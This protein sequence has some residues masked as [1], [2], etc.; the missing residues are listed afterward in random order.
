PELPV[1]EDY[2]FSRKMK[3]LGYRP[4]MTRR[5]ILTSSRRYGKGTVSILKTEMLMWY[6]RM[7]YRHGADPEELIE[8]YGDI[9]EKY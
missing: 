8:M 1:M 6:L 2:G 3:S 4:V 9:R 7:L 5:R